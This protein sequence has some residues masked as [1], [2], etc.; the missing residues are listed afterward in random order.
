M[1][2]NRLWSRAGSLLVAAVLATSSSLADTTEEPTTIDLPSI[3]CWD[4]TG[5]EVEERVPA[6]MMLYGYVA[7]KHGFSTQKSSEIAP[8]LERVGK[9]CAANPD[10]Y[11]V[12][13]IERSITRPDTA[14]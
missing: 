14:D 5:I 11:V 1:I 3:T 7:G 13:A 6:L 4:L 2:R 10:M 12:N 9:L 8:A